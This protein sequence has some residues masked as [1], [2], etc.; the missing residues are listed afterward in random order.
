M[1]GAYNCITLEGESQ[2]IQIVQSNKNGIEQFVIDRLEF[3]ADGKWKHSKSEQDGLEVY[4]DVRG[5]C[6]GREM[7][8]AD[9]LTKIYYQGDFVLNLHSISKFYPKEDGG[10]AVEFG[11]FV[12]DSQGKSP[13][14]KLYTCKPI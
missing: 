14:D 6:E 7:F 3:E 2:N 8:Q 5:L 9:E 10:L 4:S 1:D 12:E 11:G 13:I